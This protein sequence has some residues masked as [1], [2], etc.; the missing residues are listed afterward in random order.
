M[1]DTPKT[2]GRPPSGQTP[3]RNVRIAEE[4]WRPALDLARARG[5]TLT[6]VIEAALKRYLARHG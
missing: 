1:S 6:S 4:I 2:R 3:V 5:E